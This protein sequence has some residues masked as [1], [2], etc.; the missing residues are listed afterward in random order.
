MS[1]CC[2]FSTRT[3]IVVIIEF[4]P[5]WKED[6][7][8]FNHL[9]NL[10]LIVQIGSGSMWVLFF[11]C[12]FEIIFKL[13]LFIPF[14]IPLWLEIN[15]LLAGVSASS[16]EQG[17]NWMRDHGKNS[18]LS[19]FL[20]FLSFFLSFFLFPITRQSSS[21]SHPSPAEEREV[22]VSYCLGLSYHLHKMHLKMANSTQA[23]DTSELPFI[24]PCGHWGHL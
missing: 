3:L 20:S 4:I 8:F 7:R 1:S 21:Q 14:Q 2:L 17:L 9:L 22:H 24:L 12:H 15:I 16:K 23:C 11:S 13:L 10:V 18:F 6:G 5:W 19:F